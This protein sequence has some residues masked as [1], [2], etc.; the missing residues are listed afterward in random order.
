MKRQIIFSIV[1]IF[2]SILAITACKK[3]KGESNEE[4]LITTMV[5]T[6]TPQGGGTPLEFRFEDLD[7]PG[8][9]P[10]TTDNILLAAN[11]TYDVTITLLNETVNPAE[12]ITEEVEEENAAHRFY[13]ELSG[14]VNLTVSNLNNDDNGMPLGTTSTWTTTAASTGQVTITL[15]H[16]PGN[17]PDKQTP[18]PVNSPKSSTDIVVEFPVQVQ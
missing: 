10:A 7:G 8:G 12:D 2:I 3:E 11:K 14:G 9:D 5:I 16:Y 18:D 17:P 15:R 6:A 4:E 13:Y 1:I